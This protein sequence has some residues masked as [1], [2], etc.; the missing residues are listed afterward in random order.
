M[1]NR[2]KAILWHRE[3]RKKNRSRY[4]A[5]ALKKA[6]GITLE[7][8][9]HMLI[10]QN[11][12]CAICKQPMKDASDRCVDHSH[13]TGKVRELLCKKCNWAIGLFSE[14]I[15]QLEAA[16]NYLKKWT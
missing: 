7:Q 6:Y 5:Y 12:L 13:T 3:Y 1:A 8:F 4:R 10:S 14:N 9:E 16:I 11:N 2:E 15:T